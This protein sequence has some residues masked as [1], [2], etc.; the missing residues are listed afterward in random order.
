MVKVLLNSCIRLS[1]P[2]YIQHIAI[3]NEFKPENHPAKAASDKV[4]KINVI[5]LYILR[6]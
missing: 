3:G 5:I 6:I 2:L 1:L 4:I